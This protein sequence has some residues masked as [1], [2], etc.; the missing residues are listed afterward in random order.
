MKKKHV[1]N[2]EDQVHIVHLIQLNIILGHP[3]KCTLHVSY[4]V[5]V[6]PNIGATLT[7]LVEV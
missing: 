3:R 2:L 1:E 6:I 4:H 7:R 5:H